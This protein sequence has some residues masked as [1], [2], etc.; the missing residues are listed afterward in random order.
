L[1]LQYDFIPQERGEALVLAAAQTRIVSVVRI[2]L[3]T[4]K[5]V[6][7][8]KG[9]ICADISQIAVDT[10]IAVNGFFD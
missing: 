1:K 10:V 3:D 8:F 6:R 4:R 2:R 7:P 9:I 5:S